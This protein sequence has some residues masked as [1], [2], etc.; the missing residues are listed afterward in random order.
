MEN[1]LIFLSGMMLFMFSIL[2]A[3]STTNVLVAE[4]LKVIAL[5]IGLGVLCFLQK[6]GM[7]DNE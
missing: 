1:Q 2:L 4:F 3:L 6:A 7:I 5:V